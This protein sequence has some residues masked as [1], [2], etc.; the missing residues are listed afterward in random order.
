MLIRKQA[1]LEVIRGVLIFPC[2]SIHSAIWPIMLTLLILP[3]NI[4]T[5]FSNFLVGI[6]PGNGKGE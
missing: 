2:A 4:R 3:R 6:I 5:E 1:Y